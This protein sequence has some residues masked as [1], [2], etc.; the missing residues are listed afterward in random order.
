MSSSVPKLTITYQGVT[1]PQATT[2]R[3]GA[4]ADYNV[5]FGGNLNVTSSATPQA[6]LADNLT[7]N[8][9]DANAAVA[10]VIAGVDPATS[11][12]RM[13]DAIGRIY[14]LDRK[15]AVS[16]VVQA[17]VTGQPGATLSAGALARDENGYYWSSSGDVTFPTGGV[18][19]VQF[20][21]TTA[22]PIELGAGELNRIAQA[23]AGWDAISNAGAAVTGTAV[24]TRAEFEA[25]RFAS[26]SKNAHGSAAAIRGSVWDVDGV[27]DVYAYD[28]FTGA[29]VVV[30]PTSFSIPAHCVYVAVVGGTDADVATAIYKKKDGGCNLTGNTSVTVQD[31]ES[32]VSYPYPEYQISFERP[33]SLP[34]KVKVTLRNSSALPAD[35]TDLVKASV[36]AT[37]NGENGFQRARI[38]GEVYASTYYGAIAQIS[39]AVQVLSVR[40]GTTTATL[41]S[42]AVGIDQAPTIS[43]SNIEVVLS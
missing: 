21:C 36:I 6:H 35:I 29:A 32:G 24:E 38:G 40:V 1:V 37:F 16:S 22:G 43:E 26:V 19:D 5:A 8:I 25:R 23:S 17:T 2:I 4:L 3:A 11:E 30:G 39:N 27:I 33:A 9:T 12:G 42:V 15:G 20:A 13:Q 28:N 7:Q 18:V 34:I 31:T 41:D 14:F 10:S